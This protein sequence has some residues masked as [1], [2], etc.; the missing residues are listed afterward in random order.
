MKILHLSSSK[1][2]CDHLSKHSKLEIIIFSDS[3]QINNCIEGNFNLLN[4]VYVTSINESNQNLNHFNRFDNFNPKYQQYQRMLYGPWGIPRIDLTPPKI[5]LKPI[6]FP[7]SQINQIK[8]FNSI[9]GSLFA[10]A[11]MDMVGVGVEFINNGI[12]KA[13]LLGKLNITWTH[14]YCNRHN[15]RF[16]RGTPTDD[17]S[18]TILIMR[19]IVDLNLPENKEKYSQSSK[20]I[21]NVKIDPTDF[22]LK[23]IK[24]I[25]H[26]HIEHKHPG[27]LGVGSTTLNVVR[28][29]DFLTD[30]IKAS[31]EAWI[32]SGKKAAPNGSVMRIASSGCFAFWDEEIVVQ[33]ADCYC[34]VTH[35]DPRAVYCSIAAAILI[36]RYVQWNAG[37]LEN[38][39]NIDQ[40]L[41][42]AEKFV[43]EI[44]SYRNEIIF[45]TK[46]DSI[47]KMNM[48]ED[49]KIGY[50]LKAFGS[51]IWALRYCG[52][53]EEALVKVI[54]EGGDSDTNGAV[55][56]ALL[57]AKF[58]F[59]SIPHEMIECMFVKNWMFNEIVLYMQLMGIDIPPSF[60]I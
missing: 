55:V 32:S 29:P 57:G 2:I 28:H 24:W 35:Y 54:R 17:T 44:E 25:Q 9:L 60:Y 53:I 50:C 11:V 16:V 8:A 56:G 41:T 39:P 37:L 15:E 26:G 4:N 23:L 22:G 43:P 30:S 19:S 1:I 51:A 42:D 31:K 46:C 10:S 6:V 7:P 34:K 3:N 45:Y 13:L 59:N 33:I 20:I 49:G 52:S 47:E 21:K 58:G 5:V 14:P 36:A 12:A 38:E 27:G 40:C 48:S 18:Q